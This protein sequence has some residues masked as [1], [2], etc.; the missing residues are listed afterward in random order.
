MYITEHNKLF[1]FL[2]PLA[3]QYYDVINFKTAPLEEILKGP[4]FTKI[5]KLSK[6][7]AYCRMKCNK[8]RKTVKKEL[9]IRDKFF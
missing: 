5:F 1:D 3:D 4:Y 6:T 2:P 9:R 7:N 8:F